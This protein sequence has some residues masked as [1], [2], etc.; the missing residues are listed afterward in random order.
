MIKLEK[1]DMDIKNIINDCI[2]NVRKE[3]TLSHIKTSKVTIVSKS[4]EYD[5]LAENGQLNGLNSHLTVRGG[6]TK[7][8]MVWM[9]DNKFVADGGRKYYNKIK[10]IPKFG[11]CP[12]CG[13]GIVTTL[14]HYLPKTEYPTYAVT[15]FNLVASCAD[16]NK[17]KSTIVST[18]REEEFMHPYYDDFD[19]EIWLKTK[20][21]FTDDVIFNFYVEKPADWNQE[22][23]ERAKNHFERLGL[24]SLYASHCAEAFAEY[25]FSVRR[26]LMAGG[27]KLVAEDLKDRVKEKRSITK[28]NWKAALYEGILDCEDFFEKYLVAK[29]SMKG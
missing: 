25:E 20:I 29:S 24:N 18:K 10:S 8:D 11:R 4:K 2:A 5:E 17:K 23:Y 1:P 26:I 16:C 27:V 12:F 21:I 19:D 3:P 9:Y 13:V 28:N 15:P 22:K 6:A 14:D 7:D